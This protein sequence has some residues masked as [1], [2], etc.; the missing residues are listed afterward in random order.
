MVVGQNEASDPQVL[1][2]GS[3]SQSNPCG[4]ITPF[5]TRR[6]LAG[7]GASGGFTAEKIWRFCPAALSFGSS[8]VIGRRGSGAPRRLRPAA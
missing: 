3:I 8:H 5:L 6:I 2:L 1:V 7:S 4:A